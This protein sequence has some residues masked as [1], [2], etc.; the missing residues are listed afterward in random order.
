[1]DDEEAGGGGFVAIVVRAKG[2]PGACFE[3]G[4]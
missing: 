2:M 3:G 4:D 1:M